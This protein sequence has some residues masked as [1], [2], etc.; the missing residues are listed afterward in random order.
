MAKKEDSSLHAQGMKFLRQIKVCRRIKQIRNE[1]N[2][3]E[4][5][6]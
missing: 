3:E 2:R 4:V 1:H 5:N 6:V